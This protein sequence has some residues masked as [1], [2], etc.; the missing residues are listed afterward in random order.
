MAPPHLVREALHLFEDGR[1][2]SRAHAG[3]VGPIIVRQ[4]MLVTDDDLVG[5]LV[6]VRLR[7]FDQRV[8]H[9]HAALDVEVGEGRRRE[10]GRLLFQLVPVDGAGPQAWRGAGFEPRE[11]EREALEGERQ[12]DA[13]GGPGRGGGGGADK[14]QITG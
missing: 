2:V 10:V 11:G 4:Q 6:G 13:A 5:R 12:P 14:G 7:A 9:F 1:A 3:A 8:L